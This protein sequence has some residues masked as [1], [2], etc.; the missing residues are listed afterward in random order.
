[1]LARFLGFELSGRRFDSFLSNLETQ[2]QLLPL[3]LMTKSQHVNI[4]W[5]RG[6]RGPYQRMPSDVP[7]PPRPPDDRASPDSDEPKWVHEAY[8]R[9]Q[10][11]RE[12]RYQR[13]WEIYKERM[14]RI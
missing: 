4:S 5:K 3:E 12:E 1:M 9:G 7:D 8:R 11:E 2:V 14:K 6:P 13:E 10:R